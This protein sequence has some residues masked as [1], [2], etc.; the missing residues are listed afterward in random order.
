MAGFNPRPRH[1][2]GERVVGAWDRAFIGCLVPEDCVPE[3]HG[4]IRRTQICDCGATIVL[5]V[6]GADEES[7]GWATLEDQES[8]WLAARIDQEGPRYIED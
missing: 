3:A 2:H 4:S 6:S 1:A 8:Q 7:R 5:N